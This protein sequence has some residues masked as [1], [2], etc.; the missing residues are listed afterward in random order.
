MLKTFFEGVSVLAAGK[1]KMFNA[2]KGYGFIKQDDWC[3][4]FVH[5]SAIDMPGYK[6]LNKGD[7][8]I[9]EVVQSKRGPRANRVRKL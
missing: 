6:T 7:R 5:Q 9:F 1:V 3:T 8:V 4:L 2:K